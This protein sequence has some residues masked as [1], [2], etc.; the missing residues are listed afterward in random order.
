MSCNA[1]AVMSSHTDRVCEF[2]LGIFYEI[3]KEAFIV[4]V[5]V[6]VMVSAIIILDNK[7]HVSAEAVPSTNTHASRYVFPQ[8]SAEEKY[9]SKYATFSTLNLSVNVQRSVSVQSNKSAFVAAV[10]SLHKAM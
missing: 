8:T 10:L 5:S 4:K 9:L 2:T 7:Y 1:D 3:V 6:A